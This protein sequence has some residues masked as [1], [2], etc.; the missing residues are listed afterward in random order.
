M[1]RGYLGLECAW[2]LTI[3]RAYG[4]HKPWKEYV[5]TCR[6]YRRLYRRIMIFVHTHFLINIIALYIEG[7]VA[8]IG[9]PSEPHGILGQ[10]YIALKT[11][12]EHVHV[13]SSSFWKM[14]WKAPNNKRWIRRCRLRYRQLSASPKSDL[15]LDQIIRILSFRRLRWWIDWWQDAE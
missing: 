7:H 10:K 2:F 6:T 5:R 8:S 13:L 15:D 3:R 9:L 12:E 14:A 1:C 11:Q 4:S